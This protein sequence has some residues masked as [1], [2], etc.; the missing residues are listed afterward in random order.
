MAANA[1]PKF[2]SDPKVW[3]G[4]VTTANSNLDGT[5]SI[6]TVVTA[7]SNGSLVEIVRVKALVTTTSG[8]V[9]IFIHDG[10]TARLWHEIIITA[11]VPSA[12]V[13]SFETEWIPTRSLALQSG[14]SLRASTANSESMLVECQ[15]GDF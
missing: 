10:S 7:G 9:R 13:S 15:G 6:V 8:R 12:T 14:Y 2:V 1:V 4:N 3:I 5:G 11:A